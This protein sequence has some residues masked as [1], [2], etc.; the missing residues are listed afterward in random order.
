VRFGKKSGQE[1]NTASQRA[2]TENLSPVHELS[3]STVP[4]QSRER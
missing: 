1:T 4:M 2:P 3:R